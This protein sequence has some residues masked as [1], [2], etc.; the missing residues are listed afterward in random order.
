MKILAISFFF[1]DD[2]LSNLQIFFLTT[3]WRIS[4]F[5]SNDWR[6][7]QYFISTDWQILRLFFTYNRLVK[8]VDYFHAVDERISP[9]RLISWFFHMNSWWISRFFSNLL[10]KLFFFLRYIDEFWDFSTTTGWILS[11]FSHNWLKNFTIL[12]R[13]RATKFTIYFPSINGH[14]FWVISF[15]DRKNKRMSKFAASVAGHV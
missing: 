5:V 15:R 9:D 6:I 8:L 1:P 3:E 14:I 12:H 11:C 13:D 7:L 10:A 2:Q 4:Y